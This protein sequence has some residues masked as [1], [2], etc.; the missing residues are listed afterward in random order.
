MLGKGAENCELSAVNFFGGSN[1]VVESQPSK[2]LVAGSNPV[3][4]S[5][6][7]P[8][9]AGFQLLA[10]AVAERADAVSAG[11]MKLRAES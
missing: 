9:A 11:K 2:L 6:R 7:Q 4:R 8:L 5:K 10:W 1:S 3:S